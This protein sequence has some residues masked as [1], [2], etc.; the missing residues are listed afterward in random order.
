MHLHL[1][2]TLIIKDF[3]GEVFWGVEK[4]EVSQ[5]VFMGVSVKNYTIIINNQLS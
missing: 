1:V 5:L 2:S 4:Y 3:V